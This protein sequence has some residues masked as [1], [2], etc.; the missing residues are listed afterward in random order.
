MKNV[1]TATILLSTDEAALTIRYI[2]S[3]RDDGS[4]GITVQNLTTGEQVRLS[5]LTHSPALA[6]RLFDR[7]VRGTVTTVTF[8]DVVED[9]LAAV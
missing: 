6:D 4:Y 2:L 7:L 3:L 9:F 8:R 5:D 1:R